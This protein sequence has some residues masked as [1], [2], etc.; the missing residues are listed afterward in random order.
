MKAVLLITFLSFR[1]SSSEQL[2]I[3]C[4]LEI[5]DDHDFTSFEMGTTQSKFV[6]AIKWHYKIQCLPGSDI[7]NF[8]IKN[9]KNLIVR[10][11]SSPFLQNDFLRNIPCYRLKVNYGN[12]TELTDLNF[13]STLIKTL[14]LA[15]NFIEKI[16]VKSF[17]N[18]NLFDIDLSYNKQESFNENFLQSFTTRENDYNRYFV[19]DLSFNKIKEFIPINKDRT[20][21]K[22][23]FVYILNN[24][25]LQTLDVSGFAMKI[26][27]D[28]NEIN[29][30]ECADGCAN[31]N[32][33]SVAHNKLKNDEH[34]NNF[35]KMIPNLHI[36]D[37][38]YNPFNYF[39][40]DTFSE[41]GNLKELNVSSTVFSFDFG[42]F[43][44]LPYL[45]NLN[46]SYNNLN[47][48]SFKI[49]SGLEMLN[50]LDISGNN[51]N[52]IIFD[53]TKVNKILPRLSK[54]GLEGN[55]WSCE[56]LVDMKT[57]WKSVSL[58]VIRPNQRLTAR[59]NVIGIGCR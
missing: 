49:F 59:K 2:N 29:R 38:S 13:A 7:T 57:Y 55:N 39:N 4:G 11:L 34:F 44:H 56:E 53:Y 27:A 8:N 32:I 51:L 12:I 40:L 33:L 21:A 23:K 17:E 58:D 36:L 10:N 19:I 15:N 25:K 31:L 35:M 26:A 3:K 9:I 41:I 18:S 43:S 6:D 47:Q 14:N 48:I 16:N 22:K 45:I 37:L 5:I 28:R 42:H 54:I 50:V 24:N 30:L 20:R 1:I 46:I 52:D